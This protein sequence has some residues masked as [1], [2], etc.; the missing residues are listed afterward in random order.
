MKNLN[1]FFEFSGTV[2]M[3]TLIVLAGS[4]WTEASSQTQSL[5]L[6]TVS[7]GSAPYVVSVGIAELI[8][9]KTGISTTA[10]SAGGADANARLLGKKRVQMAM[11]T[12]FAAEH[13]YKGDL[14]F[15]KDGKI[16]ARGLLWGQAS[17]RQ[18]VA[19]KASEIITIGDFAG[20]RILGKRRVGADTYLT[21]QALLKAYG[22][23]EKD[24]KVLTYSKPKEIMDAFKG[25][26]ADGAIW[27]ASPP[28]PLIL[29]LQET[30]E[31]SF[32]SIPKDKWDVVLEECGSAFFMMTIKANTYKNQPEDIYVPAIQMGL[33]VHRDVPEETVYVVVKALVEN[34]DE[35]K[36][37]HPIAKHYNVENT[38]N[39]WT[40]P[41]H[42]GAIKYFKEIGAWT[43]EMDKKQAKILALGQ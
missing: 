17:P 2:M 7:V 35:L 21:F 38:L 26:M 14:Q 34:Y 37:F 6:G 43:P 36:T 3:A 18:P 33:S 16:P 27:P 23:S 20:K 32:P 22:I 12:S 5:A 8:T 4:F 25:R 41:F 10:E 19:R 24:V 28:N 42:P 15:K 1:R 29:Q 31:L 39:Q 11:L 9:K 30:V 13:A 40:L